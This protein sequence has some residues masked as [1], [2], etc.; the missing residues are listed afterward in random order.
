MALNIELRG[1]SRRYDVRDKNVLDALDVTDL[2][3]PRVNSSAS[4][5]RRDAGRA[6]CSI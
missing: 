4:W 6:P 1:V 2:S 3:M 5:V